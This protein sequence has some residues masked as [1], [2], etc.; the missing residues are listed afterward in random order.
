MKQMCMILLVISTFL[1]TNCKKEEVAITPQTIPAPTPKAVNVGNFKLDQQTLDNWVYATKKKLTFINAKGDSLLLRVKEQ[2]FRASL[3][4][5]PVSFTSRDV[6]QYKSDQNVYYLSN[7]KDS[8]YASVLISAEP[9]L[10]ENATKVCDIMTVSAP[11]TDGKWYWAYMFY[12][13]L[14][15][16][17]FTDKVETTKKVDELTINGKVYK[18]VFTAP[19]IN[20][21]DN[22][23]IIS[24]Y[25]SN[26]TQWSILKI[27]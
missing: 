22:L 21:N 3:F 27:E 23:G 5:I 17:N 9:E 24:F 10:T 1:M 2:N 6:F 19:A 8:V 4:S 26:K 20:Y 15:P 16:R 18:N 12:K 25:D 7:E 13:I 11:Y 14:N